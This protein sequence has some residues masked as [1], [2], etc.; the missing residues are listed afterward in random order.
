META[1]TPTSV[2]VP[3]DPDSASLNQLWAITND[4]RA[5]VASSLA[6][7]WVAQLSS[8]R[9]G[10][11]AEGIVWGNVQILQDNLQLRQQYPGARLLWSGDWSNFTAP[12]FWVTVVGIGFPDQ[13]GALAWCADHNRDRDHCFPTLIRG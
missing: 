12:D 2:A 7:R 8:K 11:Q 10:L 4:D 3:A 1:T 5:F 9:P 13:S 6:D